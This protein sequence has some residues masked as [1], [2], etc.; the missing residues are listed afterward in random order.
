MPIRKGHGKG[1]GTPHVEVLRA[2]KLPDGV[3]DPN[4]GRVRDARG[5]F[6]P[7]NPLAARG[8]RAR[9][10]Y[11]LLSD[12][13]GLPGVGTAVAKYLRLAVQ[14]RRVHANEL[15]NNVGGGVCGSGPSAIV[16]LA[17]LSLAWSTYFSDLAAATEDEEKRVAYAELAARHGQMCRQHLL[18]AHELAAKEAVSRGS[19]DQGGRPAAGP[20]LAT[21]LSE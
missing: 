17:S 1:A 6:L 9:A 2:N 5:H 15:S 10:D 16:N 12:Q 7:G 8:G 11:S 13:L 18:A 21:M 3:P 19:G 20:T 4:A 14:F